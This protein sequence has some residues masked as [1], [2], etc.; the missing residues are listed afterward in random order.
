MIQDVGVGMF[1]DSSLT[2]T[3]TIPPL[4]STP[5]IA[6][7]FAITSK[8]Y[9]LLT[10]F[11]ESTTMIGTTSSNGTT[12]EEKQVQTS[13]GKEIHL[14][15]LGETKSSTPLSSIQMSYQA[16]QNTSA[17]LDQNPSPIEEYYPYMS[18]VWALDTPNTHD[19][20][21][22]NFSSDEDILEVMNI[23]ERP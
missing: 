13:E 12:V 18:P 20:L 6:P 10:I 9:F 19:L 2:G 4:R 14:E 5:K 16:I 7:V 23:S 21:D 22:Q 11:T 3:F 1:K 17:D 8:V 15:K